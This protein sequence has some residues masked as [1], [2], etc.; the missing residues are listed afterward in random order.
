LLFLHGLLRYARND[1]ITMLTYPPDKHTTDSKTI[2]FTGSAKSFVTINQSPVSLYPNG[3]FCYI[4]NLALGENQ[5]LIEIDG[6]EQSRLIYT[7]QANIDN[8][9]AFAR[10]Y[11]AFAPKV[12][13]KEN[14]LRSV[15]ISKNKI[16]LPLNHP[17][18]IKPELK[19]QDR[20][21]VLELANMVYDLDW[22]HYQELDSIFDY[23]SLEGN[24][25]SLYARQALTITDTCWK[26]FS[27]ELSFTNNDPLIEAQI[28]SIKKRNPVICLDPGHGG[29]QA[30]CQSPKG[31][32]EKELNLSLALS[33]KS[34]LEK[35][36]FRVILTRKEDSDLSLAKRVEI[37]QQAQADLFLSLH[38]N[39]LPDGRDPNQERGISCHFY[40][41]ESRAIASAL[42]ADLSKKIGLPSAG[43]YQQNLH[44]LREKPASLALLLEMGYLI[45]PLESEIISQTSFQTKVAQ[46]LT[47]FLNNLFIQNS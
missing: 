17:V 39:A 23:V 16:Q 32:Q 36:G 15:I 26:D 1:G 6:S 12:R 40:D 21:L 20:E 42:T 2:F 38:H 33:L 29:S 24:K 27:Y 46:Y 9:V 43:L 7:Q 47:D 28:P 45:H 8:P 30:G 22:V 18:S 44:V 14:I 34:Q 5:F 11:P 10:H 13:S 25:L 35:N 3:N 37:S 4:V 31:I 41:R 19:N